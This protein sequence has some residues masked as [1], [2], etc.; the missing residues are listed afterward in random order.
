MSKNKMEYI[1]VIGCG[2]TGSHLANL[3]SKTGKS[4]VVID[5][6]EES[7]EKLNEEFSGFTIEADAVEIDVLEQAKIAKADAVI[8]TTNEDSINMMAAQIAKKIYRVPLVIA[9]VVE[10]SEI[11]VYEALE[12]QTI[13]PTMITA[14]ALLCMLTD[15]C[16]LFN[17]YKEGKK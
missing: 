17:T 5:K 12:I 9:K 16:L 1:I 4:V 13:S 8:I 14:E 7:F 10:P 2:R 6:E 3:L 11:P 15:D